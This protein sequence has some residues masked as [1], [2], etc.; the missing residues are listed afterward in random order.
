ML[1][2]R[3]LFTEVLGRLFARLLRLLGIRD[4]WKRR[5]DVTGAPESYEQPNQSRKPGVP[6]VQSFQADPQVAEAPLA[7][8]PG[9]LFPPG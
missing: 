8:Y 3:R 7:N 5:H 6:P 2:T 4:L 9:K 1:L